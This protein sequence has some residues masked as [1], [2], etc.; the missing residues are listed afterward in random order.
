MIVVPDRRL[1]QTGTFAERNGRDDGTSMGPG[2]VPSSPST[3]PDYSRPRAVLRI[4]VRKRTEPVLYVP[5]PITT[6]PVSDETV[7]EELGDRGDRL[8][9]PGVRQR[10]VERGMGWQ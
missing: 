5:G 6:A 10:Q 7:A 3:S 2:L 8:G 1:P 4:A 9:E